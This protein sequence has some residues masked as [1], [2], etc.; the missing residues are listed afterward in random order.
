MEPIRITDNQE[1]MIAI[2]R[3]LFQLKRDIY[4]EKMMATIIAT[5]NEHMPDATAEE[6]ERV[7]FRSIYNYW[8]YGSSIGE[9]FYLRFGELSHEEKRTY[10]TYRERFQY[11][12][13]L[14]NRADAHMLNDKYEAYQLMKPY[15][16]RDLIQIQGEEDYPEFLEFVTKHPVFVVK[17]ADLGLGLGVHKADASKY[18]DKR[19]LFEE[20]LAE[21]RG[22]HDSFT[23]GKKTAVVLEEL[24]IQAPEMAQFHPQSINSVRVTTV[25]VENEVHIF[26]PWFKIGSNGNFVTSAAFGTMDAGINPETGIVDTWG[27]TETCKSYEYHPQ[28]GVKIPGFQ[29]P[30]WN[31]AVELAKNLSRLLPTIGYTGWDL[32]LTEKGWCVM[33]G[34]FH[35]E[36]MWQ[37]CYDRGMKRELE[38]VMRW[39]PEHQFWWQNSC[40]NRHQAR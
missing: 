14:N 12:W 2:G 7:F 3:E 23:W 16:L 20:I 40:Y 24:L 38:D 11:I 26:H 35:G 21:G 19:I 33:E 31:E 30:R 18:E 39:K 15:F 4:N 37:L 22:Y 6:R 8:V 28:T 10:I 32:V 5:I 1:E 25:R 29:I 27:R 17:P 9:E 34:N 36:F 13:Q